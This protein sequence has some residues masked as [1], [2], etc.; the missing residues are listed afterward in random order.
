MLK[1][2]FKSQNISD[3]IPDLEKTQ[4]CLAKCLKLMFPNDTAN[5][6]VF[7]GSRWTLQA[8]AMSGKIVSLGISSFS[9]SLVTIPLL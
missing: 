7:K 5:V 4:P 8:T 3:F 2:T 1:K 6:F 9:T